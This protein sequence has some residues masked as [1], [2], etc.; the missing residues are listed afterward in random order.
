VT[1]R[2]RDRVEVVEHPVRVSLRLRQRCKDFFIRRVSELIKHAVS[3]LIANT[4]EN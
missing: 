1:R 2:G 4:R 3:I